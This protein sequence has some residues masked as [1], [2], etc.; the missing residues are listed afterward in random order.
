MV[1]KQFR[2]L[3]GD[4]VILTFQNLCNASVQR[5]FRIAEQSAVG[6]ILNQGMLEQIGRVRWG[7]LPKKQAGCNKAI[8]RQ[9]KFGLRLGTTAD[10]RPY[11]NSRPIA[12]PICATSF[13]G[14]SRSSRAISEACN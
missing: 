7:A 8:K 2:V 11:E 3:V 12:A 13:A 10:N 1:C 6:S 5:S 14:P 4:I 9:M